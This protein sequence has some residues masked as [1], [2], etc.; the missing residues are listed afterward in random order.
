MTMTNEERAALERETEWAVDD[1]NT[2][3]S[4]WIAEGVRPEIMCG[5]F[6][7]WLSSFAAGAPVGGPPGTSPEEILD[8][9]C[10]NLRKMT[11][12]R[13]KNAANAS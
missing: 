10:D 5:A 9:L 13:R 11:A 3:V 2:L 4:S 12:E 6:L 1:V 8:G 7:G